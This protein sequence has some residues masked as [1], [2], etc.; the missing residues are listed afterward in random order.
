[1]SW[2]IESTTRV[3]EAL[4][5]FA[6]AVRKAR[7][8]NIIMFCM[9]DQHVPSYRDTSYY[10]VSYYDSGSGRNYPAC[11][12]EVFCIGAARAG[13]GLESFEN[14]HVDFTFPGDKVMV[15]A[16]HGGGFPGNSIA[17]ALATGVAA[18]ILEFYLGVD[19]PNAYRDP[20]NQAIMRNALK[21]YTRSWKNFWFD[22]NKF[23]DEGEFI[24]PLMTHLLGT[25]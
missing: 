3:Q 7:E 8:E 17:T 25:K 14:Q 20:R 5:R 21:N 24:K 15:E 2:T 11:L 6:K 22:Y 19:D 23:S 13:K 12:K 1:M 10:D 18:M 4:E 16:V 9:G